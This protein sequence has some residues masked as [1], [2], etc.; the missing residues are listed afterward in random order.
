MKISIIGAGNIGATLAR[1]LIAKGHSVRIANSRGPETLIEVAQQTG[2]TAVTSREAID[3]VDVV[4]LSVPFGSLPQ[5][6]ELLSGLPR[7]VVVA[8][9]SNY[10]P[11]RDG[12]VAAVD[13]GQVESLWV[14]EQ[15]GRPVIKAWNNALA[16]TLTEKAAPT[17]TPSFATP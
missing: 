15:I 3:G 7:D 6:R 2:A 17:S 12:Q 8:D 4:I 11:Y 10:F 1:R 16:A 13:N 9:T 5:L 14:A